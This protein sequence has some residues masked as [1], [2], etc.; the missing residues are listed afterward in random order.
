MSLAS[1]T[2]G[3]GKKVTQ[4]VAPLYSAASPEFRQATGSLLGG[5]FVAGNKISSLV[6]GRE[7][8]PAMLSAIR[9]ARRSV[10][11]ETYVMWDGVVAKEFSEALAERAAAGVKVN[12]IL[13]AQGTQSMGMDNLSR[14]RSAGVEVVKYHSI[15]WLDPRRY[16]NRSHRKLLIVDGKVG[17]VGGV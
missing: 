13:D 15:L 1:C 14:L 10:N 9:A 16:N 17:F 7:I 12:V 11:L 5:N 6:N 2:L 4:D 3:G 8:F